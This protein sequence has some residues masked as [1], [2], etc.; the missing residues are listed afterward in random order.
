[1]KRFFALFISRPVAT[2][3]ISVAITLCGAL[4]FLFLPWR[5]CPECGVCR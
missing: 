1:M 3:L 4:S 2:T 5:H